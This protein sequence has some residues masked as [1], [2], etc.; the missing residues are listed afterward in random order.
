MTHTKP[1]P[2]IIVSYCNLFVVVVLKVVVVIVT[3][4][5]AAFVVSSV[6]RVPGLRWMVAS[7]AIAAAAFVVAATRGCGSFPSAAATTT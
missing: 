3:A 5:A 1:H 2:L 7:L 6:S 4:A